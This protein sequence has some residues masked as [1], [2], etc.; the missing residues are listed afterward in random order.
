M[1]F[2]RIVWTIFQGFLRFVLNIFGGLF[3]KFLKV[4]SGF[5]S[6]FLRVHRRFF[7]GTLQDCGGVCKNRQFICRQLCKWAETCW[8]HSGITL[9]FQFRRRG[10]NQLNSSRYCIS[11]DDPEDLRHHFRPEAPYHTL[12]RDF[13]FSNDS[14]GGHFF[15]SSSSFFTGY[16][17][18]QRRD[19]LRVAEREPLGRKKKKKKKKWNRATKKKRNRKKRKKRKRRGSAR[20][21]KKREREKRWLILLSFLLHRSTPSPSTKHQ[22]KFPFNSI[23]SNCISHRISSTRATLHPIKSI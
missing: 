22:H 4:F 11:P 20:G 13:N 6:N 12:D 8:H 16:S 2:L 9:T 14:G 18:S 19:S 21:S 23:I 15:F 7:C 17:K 3:C 10:H 5:F 1:I